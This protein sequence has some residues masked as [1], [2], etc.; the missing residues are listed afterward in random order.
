MSEIADGYEQVVSFDRKFAARLNH[1]RPPIYV[2][3]LVIF[4]R[5]DGWTRPDG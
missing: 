2:L 4:I 1:L 5:S 3:D